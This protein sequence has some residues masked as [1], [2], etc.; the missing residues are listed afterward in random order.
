MLLLIITPRKFLDC[1]MDS[2]EIVYASVEEI[3]GKT[4]KCLVGCSLA[5]AHPNL[6]LDLFCDFFD[7]FDKRESSLS[8]Q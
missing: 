6:V 2:G 3:I 1:N 8:L 7:P 4:G 5:L